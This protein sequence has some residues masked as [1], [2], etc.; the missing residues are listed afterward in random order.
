M[1]LPACSQRVVLEPVVSRALIY[2]LNFTEHTVDVVWQ[3]E[4]PYGLEALKRYGE[5]E[6]LDADRAGEEGWTQ[7]MTHDQFNF[8]GGSVYRLASGHNLVAFTSLFNNRAYNQNYSMYAWEAD[9][10]TA[11]ARST[12]IVPHGTDAMKTSGG[13]RMTPWNSIHGERSMLDTLDSN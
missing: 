2:K 10:T 12:I 11:E 1:R 7:T 6:G 5:G 4:D 9:G 3:F 13:Y 8:D